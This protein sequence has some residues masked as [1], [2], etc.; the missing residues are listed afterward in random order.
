MPKISGTET[1]QKLKEV[2]PDVEVIFLSGYSANEVLDQKSLDETAGFL[3]K[4]IDINDLYALL[5]EIRI[6][7]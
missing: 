2:N 7:K 4:P 1:L 6:N 3:N 5:A